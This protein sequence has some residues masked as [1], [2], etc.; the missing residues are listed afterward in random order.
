MA[1]QS[2]I[3]TKNL[4]GLYLNNELVGLAQLDYLENNFENTKIAYIN[5]F[6]IKENY[7]HQGLGD[8]LLKECLNIAKTNGATQIQLTSNKKRVYAHMLYNKNG[9]KTIDTILLKKEI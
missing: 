6:C 3:N 5:N 8:N 7:R 9:F 1:K 4:I 2:N